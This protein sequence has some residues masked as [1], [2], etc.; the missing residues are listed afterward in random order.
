MSM[1]N[2]W[3]KNG[4]WMAAGIFFLAGALATPLRAGAAGMLEVQ[5]PAG[6]IQADQDAQERADEAHDREQEKNEQAQERAD[7]VQDVYDS[8]REALDEDR[9]DRAEEKFGEVAKMNAAQADAA[10]YWK[11]YA[12]N[13]LGK[14]DAALATIA[15]LKQRFPQIDEQRSGAGDATAGESVERIGNPERK[16]AGHVCDGAK[17]IATSARNTGKNCQGAEQSRSAAEGGGISRAV[18]RGG[19]AQDAGGGVCGKQ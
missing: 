4:K 17:R 14:R 6:E 11:A 8:G 3:A 16:I 9:F 12:E 7:H 5:Q 10:L 1:H 19:S 15:D 2:S 13:K 18:W